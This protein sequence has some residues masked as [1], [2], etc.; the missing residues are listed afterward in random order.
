MSNYA[1]VNLITEGGQV[2]VLTHRWGGGAFEDIIPQIIDAGRI[3]ADTKTMAAN[4]TAL[5]DDFTPETVNETEL[6]KLLIS[7]RHQKPSPFA[8][9]V[10]LPS[11]A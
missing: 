8:P 7:Q 9:S 10:A 6:S 5:H 2:T 11:L 4:L 1:A 3:A